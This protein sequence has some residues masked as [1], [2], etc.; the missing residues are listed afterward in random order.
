VVST[1]PHVF[2]D[3]AKNELTINKNSLESHLNIYNKIQPGS[4]ILLENCDVHPTYGK[5]KDVIGCDVISKV[6]TLDVTSDK[7]NKPS[8]NFEIKLNLSPVD[9]FIPVLPST[10]RFLR[11]M[12]KTEFFKKNSAKKTTVEINNFVRSPKADKKGQSKIVDDF[13][14][15][16]TNIEPLDTNSTSILRSLLPFVDKE[17]LLKLLIKKPLKDKA[18]KKAVRMMVV[19]TDSEDNETM[20]VRKKR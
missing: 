15:L 6:V 18:N 2:Q 19:P 9:G 17:D 14:V 11:R 1:N 3:S 8:K 10:R 5:N 20:E 13:C 4:S 16:P 12:E 7:Q